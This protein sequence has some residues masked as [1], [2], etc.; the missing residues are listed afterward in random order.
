MN[1]DSETMI[2]WLSAR[3]DSGLPATFKVQSVRAWKNGNTS[4]KWWERYQLRK[5]LNS[6]VT[7]YIRNMAASPQ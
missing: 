3:K 2:D 7:K 4:P 6:K 1:F 5:E